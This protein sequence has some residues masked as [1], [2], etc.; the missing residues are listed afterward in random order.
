MRLLKSHAL[1]AETPKDPRLVKAD[2][3]YQLWLKTQGGIRHPAVLMKARPL[4]GSIDFNGL[5]ISIETGRSRIREWHDPHNGTQGMSRMSLPYGYI[6]GT[7]GTDGDQLDVFIGPDHQ[8]PEVYVVHTNKPPTFDAYDEDKCFL[9]LNSPE[10]AKRHFCAAYDCPEFF[11]SMSIWPF[12][13][14]KEAAFTRQGERL[15]NTRYLP[16]PE[17]PNGIM[18][19]PG[20]LFTEA[21]LRQ[22]AQDVI[23]QRDA[24]YDGLSAVQDPLRKSGEAICK[25]IG[26]AMGLDWNKYS[27]DEFCDGMFH[28]E[29]HAD[30][31]D[32]NQEK[33]A[34]IVLQHLDEDPEYY[35]HLKIA[36]DAGIMKSVLAT[37]GR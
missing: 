13:E 16:P 35:S 2:E 14:F 30:V 26:D 24:T 37:L 21:E 15:D 9:G 22:R 23:E 6:K 12:E 19:G 8:A 36:K 7:K 27:L 5:P 32:Y 11:G 34:R 17:S 33:V 3:E 25:Q 28:E 29:E 18:E 20:R 1:R 31:V 10:E 4:Q